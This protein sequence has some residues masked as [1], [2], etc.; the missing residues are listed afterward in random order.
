[1]CQISKNFR[2]RRLFYLGYIYFPIF[3]E[4]N[5]YF[6]IFLRL[7]EGVSP[8]FS[9]TTL[10][11]RTLAPCQLL[12]YSVGKILATP[13]PNTVFVLQKFWKLQK[14]YIEYWATER[15]PRPR[16]LEI[17]ISACFL[18]ENSQFSAP[19]S[20]RILLKRKGRYHL[21]INWFSGIFLTG[22]LVG[23]IVDMSPPKY[24]CSNNLL[25]LIRIIWK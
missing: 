4:N 23:V 22:L 5:I 18:S 10:Q 11:K 14:W 6:V 24:T 20:S 25:T 17:R 16:I 21:Q 15:A 7:R 13:L 3:K 8:I 19:H 12:A 9:P 2:L 1:M